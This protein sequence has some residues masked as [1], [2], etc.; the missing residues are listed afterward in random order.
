MECDTAG[1]SELIRYEDDCRKG[2][3]PFLRVAALLKHYIYQQDLP[4]INDESLVNI[5]PIKNYL[6]PVLMIALYL[7]VID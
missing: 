5:L 2:V 4:D 1:D 7:V 3:L 6:K